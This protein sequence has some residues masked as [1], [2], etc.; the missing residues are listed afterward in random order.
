[1]KKGTAIIIAAVILS[2]CFFGCQSGPERRSASYFDLFDTVIT[3]TAYAD[4]ELFLRINSEAKAEFERLNRLFDIYNEYEGINN[5]A[6]VNRMAGEYVEVEED[7][8]RLLEKGIEYERLTSGSVNIAMG[9]VLSLWHDCRVKAEEDPENARIPTGANLGEA[10]LH[11]DING[12]VIDRERGAVKLCDEEMSLDVGAIAK[13]YAAD[14][15]AE[16][17]KAYGVPFLLNCGGAVLAY[18]TKPGDKPWEAGLD[19]PSGDGFTAIAI[20]SDSA[21][22]TSGSYL[23]KFTAEGIEYGHIIDPVSMMPASMIESVT[24]EVTGEGMACFADALS[25]ACFILGAERGSALIDSIEEAEALF[26]LKDGSIITT[27][28]FPSEP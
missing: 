3:L 15:A 24:V 25:T 4:E 16:K 8:V 20:L 9:A 21:I 5:L 26:V 19:D 23:R 10:S 13:G 27:D 11:C 6:T 18:G 28:G 17:L 7:I 1:M 12:V 14:S 22:S 2:A